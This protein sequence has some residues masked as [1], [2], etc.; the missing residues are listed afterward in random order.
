MY[1]YIGHS[2]STFFP[3]GSQDVLILFLLNLYLFVIIFYFCYWMLFAQSNK[4]VS[5]R[6][7]LHFHSTYLL[8]Q[9]RKTNLEQ[10]SQ[11]GGA[12]PIPGDTQG[13]GMGL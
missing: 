5:L 13:Q 9:L 7:P 11:R 6:K 8:Q 10:V 1:V 2:W 4:K 12:C 3:R